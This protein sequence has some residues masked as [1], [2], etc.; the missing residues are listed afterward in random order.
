[1]LTHIAW[2]YIAYNAVCKG[3]WISGPSY[4]NILPHLSL[5]DAEAQDSKLNSGKVCHENQP[6]F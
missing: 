3:R 6:G 4:D 2:H 5:R 1:M